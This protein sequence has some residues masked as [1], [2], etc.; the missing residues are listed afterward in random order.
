MSTI[1]KNKHFVLSVP[2]AHIADVLSKTAR[3]IMPG[4]FFAPPGVVE[5]KLLST[6]PLGEFRHS[7]E[8]SRYTR[9]IIVYDVF[10]N[11]DHS[12]VFAYQRVKG[13]DEEKLLGQCSI[14]VGGH[15]NFEP[16][17]LDDYQD[18][19]QQSF[20][21]TPPEFISALIDAARFGEYGEEIGISSNDPRMDVINSLLI[22]DDS[23]V[24]SRQH[25]GLVNLIHCEYELEKEI[26]CKEEQAVAIGWV[27]P[28]EAKV[29]D[30][31][32]WSRILLTYLRD[33]LW[34]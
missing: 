9:H 29:D 11:H 17:L 31:E 34:R 13:G 1:P 27:A 7:A 18:E 12:K 16:D 32:K 19:E 33:R 21:S 23:D 22:I 26:E 28:K 30:Y 5:D 24:V 25:V 3:E 20:S 10:I 4:L 8:V 2:R 14:G 15:V 6:R